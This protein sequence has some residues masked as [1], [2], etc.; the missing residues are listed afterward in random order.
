[1]MTAHPTDDHPTEVDEARDRESSRKEPPSQSQAVSCQCDP[2]SCLSDPVPFQGSREPCQGD[3]VQSTGSTPNVRTGLASW[4]TA[5]LVGIAAFSLFVLA[6]H[7]RGLWNPDEPR[8]AEIC[9][10]MWVSGDLV[11][12]TLNGEPFLEKPPLYAWLCWVAYRLRGGADIVGSRLP[13]A[14]AGALLVALTV[15]SAHALLPRARTWL[16]GAALAAMPLYWWHS[17]RANLDIPLSAFIGCALLGFA[18]AYRDDRRRRSGESL[19]PGACRSAPSAVLGPGLILASV[20][21]GLGFLTKGLV[22]VVLPVLVVF[23]FLAIERDLGFLL[24]V[25]FWVVAVIVALVT[26]PWFIPFCARDGGRLAHGFVVVHH[27]QRYV[28]GFDHLRPWHYYLWVYPLITFPFSVALPLALGLTIRRW[29]QPEG[30]S[31]RLLWALALIPAAFFSLSACK[32]DLYLLPSFPAV[33][34]LS[35]WALDT[36]S[37]DAALLPRWLSRLQRATM[38]LC[39]VL[40][41]AVALFCVHPPVRAPSTVA[42]WVADEWPSLFILSFV[43]GLSGLALVRFGMGR[44]RGDSISF[45]L[46]PSLTASVLALG[47]LAPSFDGLKTGRAITEILATSSRV[48]GFRLR[49]GDLGIFLFHYRK[50]I[51]VVDTL[52]AL[53]LAVR[54]GDRILGS[55]AGL[56]P[57]LSQLTVATRTV[58]SAPVGSDEFVLIEPVSTKST[59]VP[60]PSSSPSPGTY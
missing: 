52:E 18:L 49:E 26:L 4:I 29:Q 37:R 7:R 25:R 3:P 2:V 58:A 57:M 40:M 45:F 46:L 10:E 35:I 34:L 41:I 23:V 5:L 60:R 32:R 53:D 8:E 11:A 39:G 19:S 30:R 1:M 28:K 12:P 24:R 43:F 20:A 44:Q 27:L 59:P 9:R 33:A 15:L 6:S 51:P 54:R 50:P 17:S 42:A 16:A 48:V 21:V 31:L 55:R 56:A 36:A 13:S 47:V 14:A 22:A 38:T